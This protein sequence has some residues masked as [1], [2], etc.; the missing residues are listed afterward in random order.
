MSVRRCSDPRAANTRSALLDEAEILFARSGVDGVSLR[1]IGAAIGSANT[2]VV[3]YHFGSKDALILEIFRHRLVAI[4]ARRADL[5]ARADDVGGKQDFVVLLDILCRPLLEQIDRHGHHSYAA[6]IESVIRSGKLPLRATVANEFTATNGVAARIASACGERS[7][8]PRFAVRL[9]LVLS[10]L[11]AALQTIDREMEQ[12][13][14]E[15]ETLYAQ[16]LDMMAAA[17][18]ADGR[19]HGERN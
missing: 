3:S 4:D 8:D 19:R 2:N 13:D 5:L 7:D 11:T 15:A 1:E 10:M 16:T 18:L 14:Q 17:L 9:H 12:D 6:F